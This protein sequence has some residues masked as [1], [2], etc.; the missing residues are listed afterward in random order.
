[1]IRY[2]CV[3][4]A[5]VLYLI[6]TFPLAIV[7]LQLKKR[8]SKHVD[9]I[10]MLMIKGIFRILLG[11]SGVRLIIKG[12]ENLTPDEN[13]MYVGNHSSYFDILTTY[14]SMPR[15]TG[16]IAK[17]ELQKVPGIR[18]WMRL[19][20]CIF[21]DRND[22]RS[23]IRTI[24]ESAN[25]LATNR[26][27][28]VFPEGTRS[29]DGQIKDFKEGTMK[30]ALKANVPVV[31]VAISGTAAIWERQF[32]R[33]KPGTVIVEYGKPIDVTSLSREEQKTLGAT[34]K[35]M[36]LH[37]LDKNKIELQQNR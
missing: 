1:M 15:K 6:V 25:Q 28:F 37:M 36:I 33:V 11:L 7:L 16:Y 34:T 5:V 12:K 18:T 13:V 22:V 26:S 27:I 20:G 10:S 3:I 17:K 32:P 30:M 14:V 24:K 21:I 35:D 8:A 19:I 4:M 23:S 2:V 29:R 9:Q 31:P